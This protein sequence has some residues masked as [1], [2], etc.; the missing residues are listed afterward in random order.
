MSKISI[1]LFVFVCLFSKSF[2]FF[3]P[4]P[5][6][7]R[8]ALN[9][10]N[11][12]DIERIVV[13]KLLKER[14]IS[15]DPVNYTDNIQILG[16][17]NIS[18]DNIVI[19]ITNSTDAEISLTF[20][21]EKNINFILNLLQGEITFTYN[22]YTGLVSSSGN[23]TAY[24]NNI[25]LSLNNTVIQVKNDHEPEKFGPGI[26]IDSVA[27]NDMDLKFSFDKNGTLEKLLKYINKNFKVLLLKIA[28]N[29]LNKESFLSSINDKLLDV[30]KSIELNIP[31]DNL[32]KI[33]NNLNI[34]FSMN[35]EPIIK[36]NTLEVSLEG[37]LT[38]DSY[39]YYD[40]NNITLPHIYNNT[41]LF[42]QKS[43]NSVVSQF[44]FNN[45]LDFM[46]YYGI[47]DLVITND[48]LGLS[49]INVGL[50]SIIINEMTKVYN[51]S[52]KVKIITNATDSPILRL[53]ENNKIIVNLFQNVKFFVYNQTEKYGNEDIGTIAVDANT[54]LEVEATFNVKDDKIELTVSSI[55]MLTFD[56]I[57]SLI[58]EINIQKVKDNFKNACTL[59]ILP[60]INNK[61]KELI[62]SLP[63]P[64]RYQDILFSKLEVQSH[65][66]Y[67]KIDLS[68][69]LDSIF[70]FLLNKK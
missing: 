61:I 65:V 37:R 4:E 42:T 25:S 58:G 68:P 53:N 38:G 54:E 69:K 3:L 13:A 28:E 14:E 57:N 31:I 70:K 32:L 18:L 60:T 55:T 8:L 36:N 12:G 7:I 29:E 50:I 24:L 2:L 40:V 47:F 23:G 51:S 26:Q 15:L 19:K 44:I 52:Q 62:D 67:L 56:V 9:G 48:T 30:F 22:F 49:E 64:L 33:E 66:D 20:A 5:P 10:S 11:L 59:M 16:K 43:I 41:E 39:T 63:K 46:K 45:A 1:Y 34:S 17:M 21:E 27:F 6:V 35:E